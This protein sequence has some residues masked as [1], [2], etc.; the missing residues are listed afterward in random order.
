MRFRYLLDFLIKTTC[1]LCCHILWYANLRMREEFFSNL[2]YDNS[3]Q[4]I[5]NE[6]YALFYLIFFDKDIIYVQKLINLMLSY[7]KSLF[8]TTER[9]L[10]SNIRLIL[11]IGKQSE[12]QTSFFSTSESIF[13]NFLMHT[14][15]QLFEVNNCYSFNKTRNPL[16]IF[17]WWNHEVTT[18]IFQVVSDSRLPVVRKKEFGMFK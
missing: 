6:I 12:L 1:V 4:V 5:S 13:L 18:I 16:L 15:S 17:S 8:H 10:N 3:H 9:L 2:L 14:S 11:S 7:L